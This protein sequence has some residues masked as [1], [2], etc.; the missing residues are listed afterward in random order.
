MQAQGKVGVFASV[1][2]RAFEVDLIK[3]DLVH[4]FAT[5]F[6]IGNTLD[7]Q[8]SL[9]ELLKTYATMRLQHLGL[10]HGVI[11]DA[12]Q[13]YT[14]V[15]KDMSVVLGMMEQFGRTRIL[16]PWLHPLEHAFFREL[17]LGVSASMT[18]GDIACTARLN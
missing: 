12:A 3:T 1:L 5:N 4:T 2:S 7:T 11:R 17:A 15:S 9:T 6:L 16:K 13:V 14:F 10:Q 18:D 8:I